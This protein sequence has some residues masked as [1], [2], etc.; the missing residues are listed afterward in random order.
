ME[1]MSKSLK[2]F[3]ITGFP[4]VITQR[5]G[6]IECGIFYS[7]GVEYK[8]GETAFPTYGFA[9]AKI[10]QVA[11]ASTTE[12]KPPDDEFISFG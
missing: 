8:V 12:A 7:N 9:E 11:K 4:P 2:M 5:E 1:L 6:E 3:T 10:R